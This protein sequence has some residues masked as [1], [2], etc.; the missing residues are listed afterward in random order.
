[1]EYKKKYTDLETGKVVT[2][3]IGDH[4][5]FREVAAKFQ[6]SRSTLI[7]V[8]T[9][10]GLCQKEYDPVA[11]AYRNRLVPEAAEKGMGFRILG[12]Y[13]PFDVLSPIAIEYIQENLAEMLEKTALDK[14]TRD[15]LSALREHEQQRRTNLN[16][17]GKVRWLLDYFPNVELTQLA[18]GLGISRQ[19]VHRYKKKKEDQLKRALR[20]RTAPLHEVF[21]WPCDHA[22]DYFDRDFA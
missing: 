3:S 14:A 13:G 10:L 22:F 5:P 6:I 16:T 20:R 21:D 2:T 7:K 17:E 4:L 11:L 15:A 8:M 18:A 1:M 19:V 12:E 9:E